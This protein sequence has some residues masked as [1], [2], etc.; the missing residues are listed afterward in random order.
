[1]CFF[2]G[3][4]LGRPV[5]AKLVGTARVDSLEAQLRGHARFVHILFFQL[6]LPSEIPGY[7]LGTLRY[8]FWP[9]LGA[10]AIAEIPFALATAFLG[11]SFLERKTGWLITL[12]IGG[13]V[14]S[15]IAFHYYQRKST[16]E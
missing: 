2:V 7:V 16:S 1:M 5:T 12:G 8:P 10:L 11:I 4:Y 15:G 9:Y 14:I 6:T 3:R 13:L